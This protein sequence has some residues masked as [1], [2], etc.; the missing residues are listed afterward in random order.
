M[1]ARVGKGEGE[2]ARANESLLAPA[3]S[4]PGGLN[5]TLSVHP[6]VDSLQQRG[7][8]VDIVLFLLPSRA[9]ISE[10]CAVRVRPRTP[11]ASAPHPFLDAS[12]GEERRPEAQDEAK[13]AHDPGVE[14][15]GV[16]PRMWR[17]GGGG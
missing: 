2:G 7:F 3:T 10:Q 15:R 6:L 9:S 1:Q 17:E 16:V 12:E 8:V 4:Q 14:V 11:L 13:R 5:G